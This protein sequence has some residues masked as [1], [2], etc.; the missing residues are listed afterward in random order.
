MRAKR[1]RVRVSVRVSATFV[2]SLCTLIVAAIATTAAIARVTHGHPAAVAATVPVG[3][4]AGSMRWMQRSQGPKSSALSPLQFVPSLPIVIAPDSTT[5]VLILTTM[6]FVC[7]RIILIR[8]S[9]AHVLCWGHHK[10]PR[11]GA[12]TRRHLCAGGT[13][14][15]LY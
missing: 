6:P 10:S 8:I 12:S 3:I 13:A 4:G 1:V 15:V 14:V 7:N 11:S 5:A 2:I 9:D